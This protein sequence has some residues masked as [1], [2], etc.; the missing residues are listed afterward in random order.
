MQEVVGSHVVRAPDGRDLM[1]E[2][3]TDRSGVPCFLLAGT[4]NSRHLSPFWLDDAVQRGLWLIGY[5]RPGYGGST[6]QPG[7]T[8]ADCAADVRTISDVL[9][10]DRFLVWGFS[11]GGPH[12][13]ACA[14]LLPDRVQAAATVGSPAPYGAP[15]LD[16]YAGMGELNVEDIQLFLNDP[17]AARDRSKTDWAEYVKVT[18]AELMAAWETLLSPVDLATLR[19]GLVDNIVEAIHDGLAPGDQ[20]WWDDGVAH[21]APWGFELSSIRVPVSI[22]HGR[23]DN[24]VPF[25]HGEWLAANV[26]GAT[27]MLFETEGHLSLLVDHVGDIHQWL[28]DHAH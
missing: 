24:F 28:L 25:Q 5:D 20:G 26:P 23:E 2:A 10:L 6:A 7:R 22:W 16:Y 27:P 19:R 11:G 3:M 12:V 15:G 9:G 1:V 17:A 18:S 8:V 14:A 13:L 21:M 4:P